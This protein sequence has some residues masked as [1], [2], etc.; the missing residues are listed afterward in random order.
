[1]GGFSEGQVTLENKLNTPCYNMTGNVT[2]E[3]NGDF[4]Q[5]RTPIKTLINSN[6]YK[7]IYIKVYGNNIKYSLH[8]RIKLTLAPWQYYF[9]SF[10]IKDK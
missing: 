1:M 7:G 4:I 9:Y 2:T 8:I 10:V 3:N 5:I 6:K